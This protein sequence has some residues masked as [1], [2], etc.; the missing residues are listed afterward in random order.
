[1]SKITPEAL[2]R[3]TAHTMQ[4]QLQQHLEKL[5]VEKAINELEGKLIDRRVKKVTVLIDR[6]QHGT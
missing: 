2:D 4:E 3:M 6:R 1:M 5:K